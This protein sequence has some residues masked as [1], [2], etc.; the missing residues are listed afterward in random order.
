MITVTFSS[1]GA[2]P[3]PLTIDYDPGVSTKYTSFPVVARQ[4]YTFVGWYKT[5]AFL[6]PDQ[7]VLNVTDFF[8]AA[9]HTLYAF[10]ASIPVV[11]T[12]DGFGGVST[13]TFITYDW[14]ESRNYTSYATVVRPGYTFAGWWTQPVGGVRITAWS[15]MGSSAD[16]TLYAR[17]TLAE[18]VWADPIFPT[19]GDS[20]EWVSVHPLNVKESLPTALLNAFNAWSF[21]GAND[22][23]RLAR[24]KTLVVSTVDDFRM[25]VS[26]ETH[27]V[28]KADETLIPL[29]CLRYALATLY[30]NLSGAIGYADG[31]ASFAN[32][33]ADANV[34]LRGLFLETRLGKN[35]F[36][37]QDS[38]VGMPLY[39]RGAASG[40]LG[41]AGARSPESVVGGGSSGSIPI[42]YGPY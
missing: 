18:H 28:G 40:P 7:A 32:A 12:F 25:A 20:P 30:Y 10:W 13:P 4:G 33:W 1:V 36:S 27:T 42:N 11:V 37:E 16:H 29:L 15:E 3:V 17:W 9:N 2:V 14:Y 22:E 8:V 5:D 31:V 35:R 34:Y 21:A 39:T 41:V 24:L 38:L 26:A 6:P 23:M 19:V